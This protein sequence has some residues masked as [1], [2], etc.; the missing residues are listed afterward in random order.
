MKLYSIVFFVKLNSDF[1]FVKLNFIF[2][3]LAMNQRNRI[4]TLLYNI[5]YP[6]RPMVKSRTI[7]LINFEQLPAGQ[8]AIVAVMSYSGYDIED[9]I[10]L[11]RASLGIHLFFG[12]FLFVSMGCNENCY[13]SVS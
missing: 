11:N 8:N 3:Q 6:M 13:T 1:F 4:D 9:A 5:V 12:E 7:E 2:F 10:I